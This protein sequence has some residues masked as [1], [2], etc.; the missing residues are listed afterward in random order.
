MSPMSKATFIKSCS[1][2]QPADSSR[3]GISIVR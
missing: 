1:Y 2:S 3:D